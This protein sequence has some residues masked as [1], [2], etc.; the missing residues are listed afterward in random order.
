MPAA[1]LI[2]LANKF[3]HDGDAQ[4]LAQTCSAVPPLLRL[5]RIKDAVSLSFAVQGGRRLSAQAHALPSLRH[6][7]LHAT[8]Q[9][10]A[11]DEWLDSMRIGVPSSVFI[12]AAASMD[13]QLGGKLEW[14][15]HSVCSVRVR[16]EVFDV[17]TP[18]Q[19][20]L[21]AVTSHLP[22]HV[23]S[24]VFEHEFMA[25]TAG[26][27]DDDDDVKVRVAVPELSQWTLPAGLTELQLPHCLWLDDNGAGVQ[28]PAPLIK[29]RLGADVNQS[30]TEW[31]LP[32]SL[33]VLRFGAAWSQ[34]ADHWPRLP[35]RLEEL[36]LPWTYSHPLS[37]LKLPHS[38]LALYFNTPESYARDSKQP[39]PPAHLLKHMTV[40]M[41]P[42]R[43]RSLRL[44]HFAT[45]IDLSLLPTTLRFLAVHPRQ[46]LCCSGDDPA[47]ILHQL[48]I[49]AL[50]FG[51]A[52]C[53][54]TVRMCGRPMMGSN[55]YKEIRKVHKRF[56]GV[57]EC[58]AEL[59][60][61]LPVQVQTGASFAAPS[62][63]ASALSFQMG[64]SKRG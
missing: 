22:S 36:V 39:P 41:F 9:A 56:D 15:K 59:Q 20:K 63:S 48:R 6:F 18:S 57:K 38:L 14:L 49:T 29:L 26:E 51:P 31:Q 30:L 16:R 1:L 4:S 3:L 54:F 32:A 50:E 44:P 64:T 55:Q 5:Y 45:P 42:P 62:S 24:L 35:N 33:R 37:S 7:V 43:L 46:V 58:R 12:D 19:S 21:A 40:G 28:L 61:R 53:S 34:P 52:W 27:D 23:R 60:R 11:M 10:A 17:T 2:D 47:V 8:A 25:S 13:R